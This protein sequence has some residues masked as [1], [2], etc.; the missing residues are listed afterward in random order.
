MN[1]PARILIVDDEIFCLRA[2]ARLLQSQD[3][4]ITTAD[5]LE[6]G[7]MC[8]RGRFPDDGGTWDAVITDLHLGPDMG[9]P[10]A[11]LALGRGIPTLVVTGVP[12]AVPSWVV[13]LGGIVVDKL[14]LA[15]TLSK[16]LRQAIEDREVA[17]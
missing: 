16:T 2:M 14:D 12:S 13:E 9:T 7:M 4:L 6:S 17:A 3:Y 5:S 1:K 8:V 15:H 11:E 10:I